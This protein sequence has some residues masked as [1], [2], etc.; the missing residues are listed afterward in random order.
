MIVTRGLSNGST[1]DKLR[2]FMVFKMTE[3]TCQNE[4]KA[5]DYITVGS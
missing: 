2:M 1:I 4:T 3:I 5:Y